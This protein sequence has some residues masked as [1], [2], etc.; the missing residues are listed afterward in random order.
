MRAQTDEWIARIASGDADFDGEWQ[1]YRKDGS[2]VW[3][4]ATTRRI[5]DAAGKPLGIMGV[6][7]DISERKRNEEM[8]RENSAR[9]RQLA[10]AMPQ[11]VFSAG[12]DGH[13]DYFNRQ[14]Y[15]YTGLP[16]GEVGQPGVE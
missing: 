3:I 5:D 12:P 4:E 9:F 1:D 8:L 13:V 6:S 14:W 10:D 7:R 16:P 15:E 11:I 2:A